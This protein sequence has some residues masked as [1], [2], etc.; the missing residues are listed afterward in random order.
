[1]QTQK[2][3]SV[4][5]Q[6]AVCHVEQPIGFVQHEVLESGQTRGRR[7]RDDGNSYATCDSVGSASFLAA[8]AA[9]SRDPSIQS[10]DAKSR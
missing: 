8:L 6:L 1:M 5:G 10:W 9:I 4:D 2:L 3:G 7:L